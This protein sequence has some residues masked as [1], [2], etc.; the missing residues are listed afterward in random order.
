MTIEVWSQLVFSDQCPFK[1]RS[2]GYGYGGNLVK[3]I[4]PVVP[5]VYQI[6]GDQCTSGEQLLTMGFLLYSKHPSDAILSIIFNFSKLPEFR[7][8]SI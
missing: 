1:L 5:Y 7:V 4:N 2:D 8:C 3:D 6:T